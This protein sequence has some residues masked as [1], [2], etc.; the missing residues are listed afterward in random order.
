MFTLPQFMYAFVCAYSGETVYDAYYITCY[1][2]I[3]TALP[4]GAKAAWD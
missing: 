1:N 4:L 3:F 2:L